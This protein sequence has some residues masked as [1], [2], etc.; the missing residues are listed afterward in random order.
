MTPLSKKWKLEKRIST[1]G[2]EHESD[3]NEFVENHVLST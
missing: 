3:G 2:S 1:C